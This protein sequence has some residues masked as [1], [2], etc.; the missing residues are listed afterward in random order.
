MKRI[1]VVCSF[2]VGALVL[3]C[4]SEDITIQDD[5]RVTNEVIQKIKSFGLNSEYVEVSS[6]KLPGGET[7]EVYLVEGD[8]AIDPA[9]IET[10][11]LYDGII[12][13][14]YRTNHLVEKNTI[15][16]IGYT[17]GSQALTVKMQDGL[18]WAV[19]NFQ[20]ADIGLRFELSFGSDI[21][22]A[23]IA[24]YTNPGA[25]GGQS[26]FPSGG[27]P[28]QWVQIFGDTDALNPNLIEHI[29][30]HEIGHCIGLRHTDWFSKESCDSPKPIEEEEPAGAVHIVRTPK[31]YDSSSLMNSCW[32]ENE[33]GE[34]GSFDIVALQELYPKN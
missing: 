11:S 17:A 30:T 25:A 27:T 6:F 18:R 33:D 26:G 34:F 2:I 1:A 24:V 9:Q 23:D 15:K 29:I 14:H 22:S 19:S 16:I 8:I 10:L 3:S 5:L 20:K 12:E 31:E 7:K 13:E 4:E 28:Y 21:S 32:G